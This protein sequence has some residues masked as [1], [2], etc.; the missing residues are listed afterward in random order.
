MLD[1]I[2][3]CAGLK[4]QPS[5]GGPWATLVCWSIE[6]TCPADVGRNPVATGGFG[7]QPRAI[8]LSRLQRIV[9]LVV[10]LVLFKRAAKRPGM[11]GMPEASLC[12]LR[13]Q[14]SLREQRFL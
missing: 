12:G 8:I 3:F 7:S 10:S 2:N 1:S 14:A 13:P 9:I 11:P 5:H 4:L 6:V